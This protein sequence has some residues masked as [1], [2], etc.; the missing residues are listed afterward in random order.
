MI[1]FNCD[2]EYLRKI[3]NKILL[4]QCQ[5][6]KFSFNWYLKIKENS[7]GKLSQNLIFSKLQSAHEVLRKKDIIQCI[8]QNSFYAKE[9]RKVDL[10]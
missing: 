8:L 6:N 5:K 2:E 4:K 10:R 3:L 1:D 9:Q 7:E